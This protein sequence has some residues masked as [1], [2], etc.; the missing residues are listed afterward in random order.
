MA[1]PHVAGLAAR[2]WAANPGLSHAQVRAWL[3]QN[4]SGHDITRADLA[5]PDQADAHAR[6]GYDIP[7][8]FGFPQVGR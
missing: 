7:S 4:A 5:E 8:G 6:A 1:T 2:Y 3:Q